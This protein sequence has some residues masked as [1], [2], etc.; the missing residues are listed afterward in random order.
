MK[1]GIVGPLTTAKVHRMKEGT[2]TVSFEAPNGFTYERVVATIEPETTH[3][4]ADGG[5]KPDPAVQPAEMPKG[6]PPE[7][8][9]PLE[10][11]VKPDAE[12]PA[13][14]E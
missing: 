7:E 11:A 9:T 2:Y 1:V 10:D 6:E 12:A 3:H 14:A 13:P 5:M 4:P 8:M